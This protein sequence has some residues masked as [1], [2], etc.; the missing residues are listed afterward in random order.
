MVFYGVVR[1]PYDWKG[2]N[3]NKLFIILSLRI[4]SAMFEWF[5]SNIRTTLND[6]FCFCFHLYCRYVNGRE[7]SSAPHNPTYTDSIYGGQSTQLEFT[8][9]ILT[10]DDEGI[11]F[12]CCARLTGCS[13]ACSSVCKPDIY[14]EHFFS[15]SLII[16][17]NVSIC[18]IVGL[19]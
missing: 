10:H 14:C 19:S 11:E 1:T 6:H 12:K 3:S 4:L 13:A 17:L 15:F 5:I 16:V 18:Q 9:H 2:L 8:S 7:T